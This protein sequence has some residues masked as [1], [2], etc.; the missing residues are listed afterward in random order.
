MDYCDLGNSGFSNV[1]L[2]SKWSICQFVHEMILN[3]RLT[4]MHPLKCE[5]VC[6][7]WKALKSMRQHCKCVYLGCNEKCI[8]CSLQKEMYYKSTGPFTIYQ[9]I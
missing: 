9:P 1:L 4:L 5:C 7:S 8:E 6:D 2:G 3:S